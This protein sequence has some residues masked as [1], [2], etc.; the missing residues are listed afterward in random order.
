MISQEAAGREKAD[1]EGLISVALM[2][3]VSNS[4]KVFHI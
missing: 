1:T 4:G 3:I 2:V